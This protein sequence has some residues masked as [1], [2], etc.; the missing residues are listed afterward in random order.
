MLQPSP[1]K[2]QSSL[3]DITSTTLTM[4]AKAL[5]YVG[6]QGIDLPIQIKENAHTALGCKGRYWR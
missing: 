3:I 5:N 4:A 1:E 2:T 6:M